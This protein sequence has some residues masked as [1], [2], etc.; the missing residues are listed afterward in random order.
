MKKLMRHNSPIKLFSRNLHDETDAYLRL[1]KFKKLLKNNM[2]VIIAV[3]G[4][5]VTCFFVPPDAG[6]KDYISY[7]TILCLLSLMLVVRGLKDCRFFGIMS[8]KILDRISDRRAISAV[9]VFLP[10]F[11]ALFITNDIATITFIPF[12]IIMLSSADAHDLIPY[13]VI[14]QTMAVKL[15]GIVSPLGNAQNLFLIDYYGFDFFWFIKNLWPLAIT[16]YGLTFILCMLIKPGKLNPPPVGEYR[17]PKI[18]IAIYFIMFVFII[19][20]VFDVLP[21]YIVTPVII[22]AMIFVHPR[23]FKK[24]N[25]GVILMFIA[26]FIMSGNFMRMPKVNAFLTDVISGNELWL[27]VVASQLFTNNPVALMFPKFSSD[28]VG[29]MFGINVGKY[30]TAP[31]NNYMVMSLERKYDVK[32]HFV[33]KLLAMNFIYLLVLFGVSA[34]CVYL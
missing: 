34:L 5:A 31:L 17:L 33:L 1:L 15:S 12:A 24:A 11:F 30:G 8:G 18:R 21:Y 22:G 6:Y 4:A 25:Y 19:I 14:L 13:V 7:K 3:V 29:L 23:S 26:F 9:L 16:G 2:V 27:S 32:K 10:A 20:S 28:T